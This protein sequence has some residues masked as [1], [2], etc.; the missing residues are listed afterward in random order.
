MDSQGENNLNEA[1]PQSGASPNGAF[2]EMGFDPFDMLKWHIDMGVD[3]AISDSPVNWFETKPETAASPTTPQNT[4]RPQSQLGSGSAPP[5]KISDEEVQRFMERDKPSVKPVSA[6]PVQSA[7]GGSK[8]EATKAATEAQTLD[9]LY[10]AIDTFDG[11]H[12]KRSARHTV[13]KD[14]IEG[15][16]VMVVGESPGYE[17]DRQGKPF[18]GQAGQM[19]DAMLASIGL[20]RTQNVYITNLMPWR[21]IGKPTPSPEMVEMCL[22]FLKRHIELAAPKIVLT[23]GKISAQALLGLEG[24]IT[25]FHGRWQDLPLCDQ[26]FAAMPSYHPAYLMKAPHLKKE[27]WADLL[28]VEAKLK[29]MGIF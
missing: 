14:G 4:T 23:F 9:A 6:R 11:G 24:S 29:E 17:E 13:F 21:P 8:E 10:Q 19:L 22:P 7:N 25:K 1:I 20:S 16:P 26:T 3:E 15:A 12:I 5:R 27:A 28:S 18:I 2:S